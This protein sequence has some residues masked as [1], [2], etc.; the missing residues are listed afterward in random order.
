MASK[1]NRLQTGKKH[2][3]FEKVII[4]GVCRSGKTLLGRILGT[5]ENVEFVDEPWLATIIPSFQGN[6]LIDPEVA[7]EI[8]KSYVEELFNDMILLRQANFRP[9]DQSSIWVRKDA[10][11]ILERLINVKTREDVRKYV[12][13]KKPVL[14]LNL[15][16]TTLFIS[17]LAEVFPDCKI[18]HVVRNGLDVA[19]EVGKKKWYSNK[20]LKNPICNGILYKVYFS[21]SYSGKYYIPWWVKKGEEEKFLKIN[22]F[23]K[24]LYF[25]R[26]HIELDEKEI[27]K[28]KTKRPKQYMEVRF[29]KL[30]K[31]PGKVIH[32]LSGFINAK[33]SNQTNMVVSEVDCKGLNSNKK[34]PLKSVTDEE[35]AKAKKLLKKLK[36]PTHGF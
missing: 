28:F 6:K 31:N 32:S 36:Y 22:D 3:D 13:E 20:Q 27:K 1:K 34:Y 11:V 15:S 5:L 33:Y 4:I 24:G 7:K 23:A 8:M 10:K 25:W 30:L 17:F 29:E 12:E 35:K 9:G 2:L 16:S 26:R 18:I 14:L 19:I 21:K